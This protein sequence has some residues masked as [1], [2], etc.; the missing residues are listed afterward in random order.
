MVSLS[1]AHFDRGTVAGAE[2]ANAAHQGNGNLVQHHQQRN[3]GVAVNG[4]G[5]PPD[6]VVRPAVID[7]DA[8]GRAAP[9]ARG[10]LPIAAAG[11]HVLYPPV[12]AAAGI[13]PHLGVGAAAG[14]AAVLHVAA[15]A[16]IGCQVCGAGLLP[17]VGGHSA[18]GGRHRVVHMPHPH[19]RGAQS[20]D[21]AHPAPE[22]AAPVVVYGAVGGEDE[23]PQLQ[24]QR[25]NNVGAVIDPLPDLVNA[26]RVPT[27]AGQSHQPHH[28]HHHHYYQQQENMQQCQQQDGGA[29]M[30]MLYDDPGRCWLSQCP[31]Y[32]HGNPF[33]SSSSGVATYGQPIYHRG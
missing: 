14:Q 3:D 1:N 27:Q 6:L 4:L 11:G 12:V 18:A 9:G 33:V 10:G 17:I 8:Y 16:A 20:Q 31:A 15:A 7:A 22:V 30:M 5:P 19:Q 32:R 29:E 24:R 21:G 28:H 25:A 13:H 23:V 2:A 26:H